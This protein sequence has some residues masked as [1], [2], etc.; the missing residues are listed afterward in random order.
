MIALDELLIK[1]GVDGSQAQQISGY[2]DLLQNGADSI[3]ANAEAINRKLDSLLNDVSN[4]LSDASDSAKK[5]TDGLNKAGNQADKTGSKFSKLKVAMVALVGGAMLFGNKIASA[6]NSAVGNAETLFKSKNALYSISKAEIAQVDE[7][8]KS[9]DKTLLSINS[10]KTKIAINL[11]PTI[12]AVSEKFNG[13]LLTNKDLVTNGISKVIEWLGKGVQVITNFVKFVDKIVRSTIGWKNAFIALGVAWAILNRA[14][15]FSP[16]GILIVAFGALLLL[17]DDLMV[18]MAGGKSL[19]GSYWDPLIDGAKSAIEWFNSLSEKSRKLLGAS[20]ILSVLMIAFSGTTVKVIGVFIKGFKMMAIAVRA[21]TV[22]MMSNPILAILSA[23]A[24][25]A[26]LI[27]D[28]WDWL[29]TQFKKIWANISGFATEAWNNIVSTVSNAIKNV[30]MYFGMSEAGATQVVD[31][32]GKAFS[33]LF[34]LI[35][36]PF[37]L[38]KKF[39]D[40]LLNLWS[41]DNMT[42]IEKLGGSFLLL[43]DSITEPF[44]MA[45][46]W[47]KD[48][49]MGFIDGIMGTLK[50]ALSFIGVEIEWAEKPEH[51]VKA[52]S[53]FSDT[54]TYYKYKDS[55]NAQQLQR[56]AKSIGV[57]EGNVNNTNNVSNYDQTSAAVIPPPNNSDNRVTNNNM[58]AKTNIIVNVNDAAEGARRI[59]DPYQ[60]Q[61]DRVNDNLKHSMG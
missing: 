24:I 13:W 15:L 6:F 3:G 61:I 20:G 42:F 18:Y 58:E 7:Y 46:A 12:T 23:I 11:I 44:K 35:T 52:L 47:I 14:F 56:F 33:M 48:K 27:Y 38:A 22:V 40:D 53:E 50:S 31:D 37:S 21:L 51:E 26:Y 32:I 29:S 54:D 34:D 2:V 57:T 9:L 17:V 55:E 4:S 19:F 5:A 41:D 28:N 49:F 30:L 1:I 25:A 39:I 8:K 10:I 60:Q 16:I 43:F 45:M 36:L 59:A